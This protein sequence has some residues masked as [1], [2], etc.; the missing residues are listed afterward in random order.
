[1]KVKACLTQH[2]PALAV[3]AALLLAL[4]AAQIAIFNTPP[5]AAGELES[6]AAA[7]QAARDGAQP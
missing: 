2:W 6:R 5:M 1:M 7:L 3:T 4:L